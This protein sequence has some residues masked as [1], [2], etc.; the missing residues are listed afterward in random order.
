MYKDGRR[1]DPMLSERGSTREHMRIKVL[2]YSQA[3]TIAF[4][5]K[6]KEGR[7]SMTRIHDETA[8]S[9]SFD[10]GKKKW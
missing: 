1:R 7:D 8:D 3:H 2:T 9:R 10:Y 6:R 5:K 4:Q